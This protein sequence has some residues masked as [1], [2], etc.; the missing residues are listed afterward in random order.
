MECVKGRPQP[1]GVEIR[2]DH[3]NFA[4][5]VPTGKKCELLLYKKGS[6]NPKYRFEMPEEKGIGE[7][8]FLALQGLDTEKYEYNFQIDERVWIDPY[9][10]E[11]AGTKKFG[12][13]MDVQKH[14]ARGKF[15]RDAYDW[16]DDKRPH[17][18]WNDVI[19]Y[20]LHIRG[21]T[22][23]SSSHAV[24]K[25][26]YL[27]IVEKIP[28]LLQ[29]GINQIQ[30]MP[31][32]EFDEY[33]QNKINFWGY[34]KGFYFAPKSSYASGSS[35]VKELKDMV[36]ACHRA[37]IEVVREMP[38]EAGISA[39]KAMEC[40]KFYLLEYHVDGFVVN[41]YNVPWDELNA[42]PL[43]KEVKIMKKEEGFQTIM[44]RF[45][46]GDE[47]MI[48][49]VMWALKHNSSADGV[50]NSITA[51]TGFTLW[52]LVSYDGKH[53]EENG[54]RNQ[55]GPD[56]NYSWNCGAEG[57]SRKKNII[58]LRKNQVKNAYMLLLTAQGTP[59]LLAGDEFY[60]SQ[61]GNNNAY[62]QDNPVGWV[63]WSQWKEDDPLYLYVQQ[64]IRFRKE[65][66]CLHQKEELRGI[67]RTSCGMPDVSYHGENAWQAKAEVASRQ[68]G[69][70]YAAV[71]GE[72]ELCFLAYNMHWE[73][74]KFALPSAGKGREWL[75]AADTEQGM[76]TEAGRMEDQ[77]EIE[78]G[79]R[80]IAILINR[81]I[82]GMTAGKIVGKAVRK[83][84]ENKV[85]GEMKDESDPA[86]SDH[87]KA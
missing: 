43:L 38:F 74:H 7:V 84:V 44:R 39:Q 29:L 56:Y 53:N 85:K 20:S 45:L 28:Y 77:K 6:M 61:K 82:S 87:Y 60:N 49:D 69:V 31:V 24:H 13:R 73:V 71:K 34:G 51:Q 10:R 63:N 46:K 18:A 55:D 76:L 70:M 23:H 5:Q 8:R 16:E 78:L 22:K 21:F 2:K 50:C 26:T 17:L 57:P 36:K 33:V 67:D 15:V 80:S 58:R 25:G 62:C 52:D 4:V 40:L 30:C 14:Q 27:G 19:A 86:F 54:E 75:L 3:I 48:R 11:L 72:D 81:K 79:A 65:H 83:T 9:V 41:P 68:L 66:A 59:C 37:G 64:L 47:N 1:F 42:D 32:Y 35:A 12:V